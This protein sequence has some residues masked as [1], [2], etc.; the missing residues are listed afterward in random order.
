LARCNDP[1]VRS[2]KDYGGRGI[3]VC[4]QWKSFECFMRDMGP[5][6]SPKHSLDRYPDN[7]GN[8]ES[9][10]CRWATASEQRRNARDNVY[11]E[12]EGERMLLVVLMERLGLNQSVVAGRL[13]MGWSLADALALPTRP[14]VKNGQG[15][16]PAPVRVTSIKTQWDME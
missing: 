4:E 15:K 8:Y 12:Y 16:K 9:S 13:K 14:R 1:K 6:P 10:N 11:V 2:Y 5:K 3:K 7:N